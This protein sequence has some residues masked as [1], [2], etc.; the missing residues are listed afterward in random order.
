[1]EENQIKK[2]DMQRERIAVQASCLSRIIEPLESCGF[3]KIAIELRM[4]QQVMEDVSIELKKI[5]NKL[6][7]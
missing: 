1:M 2:L 3:D 6:K 4:T 5:V 7:E